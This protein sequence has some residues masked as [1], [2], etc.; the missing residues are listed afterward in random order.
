MA[1]T[2]DH[3]RSLLK[4]ERSAEDKAWVTFIKVAWYEEKDLVTINDTV[5]GG[6]SMP[7][8]WL[9]A[10][11]LAVQL[12]EEFEYEVERRRQAKQAA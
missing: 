6:L 7:R 3:V 2:L 4:L 9:A 1:N 11:R 10:V 12:V 8:R 5:I